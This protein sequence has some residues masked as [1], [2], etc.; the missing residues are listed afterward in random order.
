[1]NGPLQ[2]KC[3]LTCLL[4]LLML[5]ANAQTA[6]I[7]GIVSDKETGQPL[8]DVIVSIEKSNNHIHSNAQGYFTFI[9]LQKGKHEI[10]LYKLG[11]EQKQITVEL[12]DNEI[13]K[14]T[15]DL[16]FNTHTLSTV[17]IETDKP[18]SAASSTY[19]TQLDFGN[20][21]KNSAQDMLR[22]VPGL[23][24]AQ[25]AG[26]GK[27]E[28]IFIRG[29]DCD[30][31]TDVATFVDGIPVNMPSHGH[32]QGYEDLHFL[33]PEVVE[34]MSVFKGPYAPSYGNFATGAAI[35][36]KTK[37]TLKNNFFQFENT[38]VP[39]RSTLT[40]NR[41]LTMLRLPE[42][43]ASVKSYV[44]ADLLLNRGYFEH[45]QHLKRFNVFSKNL[46]RIN[47]K[48]NLQISISG[49]SSS[50]DASGQIPERAVKSGIITRF[51]SI[52]N[53]EGGT[54]QRN[55][56]NFIY[57][58]DL[59]NGAFETQIYS[60]YYRFK[61]FSNF[62]FFL[63]DSIQGDG[64]EQNDYRTIHG[65]QTRY[66]LEHKINKIKSTFTLGTSVRA[67]AIEN[68]LWHVTKR[69]RLKVRSNASIYEQSSGI[70]VNEAFRF[71]DFFKLE[72]G[73]RYDYHIFDVIDHLASDSTHINYSGYNYQTLLSPKL[74]L[75]FT[76]NHHFQFYINS[77]NG[78]HSNDA[79]SVVQEKK[80]HQLPRSWGA[81]MGALIRLKNKI[82]FS[83]A[84]W[85][86]DLENELVYVGDAG[87]TENK[88][89]SRRTGIDVSVRCQLTNWLFADADLNLSKNTLI[90]RVFGKSR[91][92]DSH[93][94]LAP[95]FTSAGGLIG[96]FKNKTEASV[97]YRYM[98]NRPANEANT[99]IA[100]GYMIY[101][102]FIYYQL[103]HF[104]I[105]LVVENI[106]N[107]KW[108]EAQF[109][110]ESKLPLETKAVSEL[111]FTPGTPLSAKV[112]VGYTF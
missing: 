76:P 57:Q 64:I 91:T 4:H 53:T 35:E 6:V 98:A 99:I 102:A 77:G 19:L 112:S 24:I 13:R 33:I 32:G 75:V 65:L 78:Y 1:M 12:S 40:S 55:N 39:A 108:N 38:Y 80:N 104:K 84:Y 85:W 110:T 93:I 105:G 73:C 87:T 95:V 8:E 15:I 25:H 44:A 42:F 43:N 100:Q 92:V 67:D 7:S 90:D 79:R 47:E 97:R 9:D 18:L 26:G 22:L 36:F 49:F 58:C 81:E 48:S 63:E 51:G 56:L 37:D 16:S 20:R 62:T 52:D 68:D 46:F 28:Q 5:W 29:F 72:M 17:S 50:W 106:F 71:N 45:D 70:Y 54:T 14:L 86:L 30:H 66:R 88:G 107:A 103:R 10:K 89:A 69:E 11:Y 41:F 109:D 83:V 96:K 60:S 94:P 61:L 59:Q 3:V 34:D 31:G 2:K 23:F 111:H 82:T 101:D 21:P 27:A 74:N